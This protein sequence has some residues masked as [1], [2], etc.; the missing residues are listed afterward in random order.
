MLRGDFRRPGVRVEPAPPRIADVP[1]ERPANPKRTELAEWLT[2][3]DHPLAT[4][5]IANRHWQQHFGEGLCRTPSDF[6]TMGEEPEHSELLD[7]LATELPRRQWSQNQL[8]RLIVTSATYR[9]AS[10]VADSSRKAADID[11]ENRLWWRYPVRRI[12]AESIRDAMLAACDDLSSRRGGRGVMAPL[13]PELTGTLLANHWQVAPDRED[14]HRRSIY[15]F[16]RRN[17]RYPVLDAF[18]RP[19]A[20]ASCAARNRSTTAPQSLL[21]L[22]SEFTLTAARRL[23][24]GVLR[25]AGSD[26][27]RQIAVAHR[28][29]F[30]RMPDDAELRTG[31]EFLARQEALISREQRPMNQLALPMPAGDGIA[32]SAAAAL[33]DY[34][35]AM[36][37]ANEFLYLD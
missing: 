7:Y 32:P 26:V 22:N 25:Q 9:Q 14:H 1:G 4:R 29:V 11:P 28:R 6:G 16:A 30:G 36:F 37:N 5:V 10:R 20:Q 13:P 34:C 23:A 31:E 17:L 12:E 2:R 18:D 21:L 15:L 8:K 33:V 27:D 24:G 3:A 19:D 35:V